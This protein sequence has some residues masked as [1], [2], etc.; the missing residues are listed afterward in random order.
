MRARRAQLSV[1]AS[2]EKFL[3]KA[4]AIEVD[5]LFFDLEDSVAPGEKEQ[6]RR[7][8]V[9]TLSTRSFA[10]KSLGV[11]VNELR[12]PW[13]LADVL[14]VTSITNER[15]SALVIP[16]VESAEEVAFLARLLDLID[17]SSGRARPLCLELQIET[18]RGLATVQHIASTGAGRVECLT[19]GPADMA[20]SLGLPTVSVGEPLPGYEGLD[21]FHSALS[22]INTAAKANGLQAIDGPYLR[23]KDLDGLRASARRA[24]ALGFDGKWALHPDQISVIQEVFTPSEAEQQKARELL[25]RYEAA[26]QRERR[27]AVMFGDEMIDEASRKQ[28]LSVLARSGA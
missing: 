13:C 2:S 17:L 1:P 19:F 9:E 6:A 28:A 10:A 27:G 22:Q 23:I 7:N 21:H 18:A 11:R 12:S 25:A 16:K 5:S 8:V 20:A 26:T 24:R 15:L 14:A 3:R 4:E